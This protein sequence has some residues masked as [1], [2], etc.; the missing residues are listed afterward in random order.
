MIPIAFSCS[1]VSVGGALLGM[2]SPRGSL[3]TRWLVMSIYP[4]SAILRTRAAALGWSF[5]NALM[6]RVASARRRSTILILAGEIFLSGRLDSMR[7]AKRSIFARTLSFFRVRTPVIHPR[8]K[9]SCISV[10]DGPFWM[11]FS[12]LRGLAGAVESV[13]RTMRSI[14]VR[15][16]FSS[17][18]LPS[19]V[20]PN[21][22]RSR[23][24]RPPGRAFLMTRPMG[25][26]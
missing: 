8:F 7:V 2:G 22:G 19:G 20:M 6:G 5:F 14:G 24:F 17:A 1:P 23:M 10:A 18:S 13:D 3:K 11:A 25:W 4:S 16:S 9:R 15:I 26:I 12:S 21:A